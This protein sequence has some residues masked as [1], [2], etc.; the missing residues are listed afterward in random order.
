MN[1][2]D[3][4][5]LSSILLIS[6]PSIAHVLCQ[7]FPFHI[8]NNFFLLWPWWCAAVVVFGKSSSSCIMMFTMHAFTRKK[9][10][11]KH[12]LAKK[13]NCFDLLSD[14]AV[15]FH[16]MHF[17]GSIFVFFLSLSLS[18]SWY[19][20]VIVLCVVL[21]LTLPFSFS[22]SFQNQKRR[23]HHQLKCL[24]LSKIKT[25]LSDPIIACMLNMCFTFSL[26]IFKNFQLVNR[27]LPFFIT[28]H[29]SQNIFLLSAVTKE[30]TMQKKKSWWVWVVVSR[31]HFLYSVIKYFS[32]TKAGPQKPI[33]SLF[34]SLS[35]THSLIAL[36]RIT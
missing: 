26:N 17:Y 14:S 23:H 36:H 18:L 13:G 3:N 10:E 6:F 1:L 5:L 29:R 25:M 9:R 7:N 15:W 4:C 22:L 31:R 24:C 12:E 16:L 30:S 21:P 2:V 28:L 27:L 8:R 20:W 33:N 32:H 34:F 11:P 35:L 19:F